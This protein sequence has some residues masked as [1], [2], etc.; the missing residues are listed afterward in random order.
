MYDHNQIMQTKSGYQY[1]WNLEFLPPP[2]KPVEIYCIEELNVIQIYGR[3][4]SNLL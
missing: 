2:L 3:P 1:L 4:L